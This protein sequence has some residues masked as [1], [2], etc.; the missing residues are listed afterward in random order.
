M[1]FRPSQG[2]A[3]A[4]APTSTL[5]AAERNTIRL[6][7]LA[8][9]YTHCRR[10]ELASCGRKNIVWGKGAPEAAVMLITSTVN[11]YEDREGAILDGPV[12]DIVIGAMLGAG[13][14]PRRD[15]YATP[16]VKCVTPKKP[17]P[18]G[19]L[20]RSHPEPEHIKACAPALREQI[21]IIDPVVMVIHGRV[22]NE[23]LLGDKRPITKYAGHWRP[24]AGR[25]CL[26]VSTHNLMRIAMDERGAL[27][28][29][30]RQLWLEVAARV[31]L[32]GRL[33]KPQLPIFRS[34]T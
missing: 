2:P 1:G 7:G 27:A 15:V 11:G 13:F 25:N 4:P 22:A 31:N 16:L 20:R 3:A 28:M 29:E 19:E 33:W 14:V 26:A 6:D 12:Y 10:C 9:R 18:Q 24:V 34:P 23:H 5:S 17:N 30:Y 32:L 8:N 21:E